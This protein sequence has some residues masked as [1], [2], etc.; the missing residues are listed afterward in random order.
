MY[1]V[2]ELTDGQDLKTPVNAGGV[3]VCINLYKK[4]K[5]TCSEELK[6]LVNLIN[7]D[8]LITVYPDEALELFSEL[9][10]G[11]KNYV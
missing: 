8:V 2:I 1:F 9:N 3:N 6:E 7:P 10:D 11:L 4:M 5:I